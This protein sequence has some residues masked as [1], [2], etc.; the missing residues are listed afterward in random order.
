MIGSGC[1]IVILPKKNSKVQR[2]YGNDIYRVRH[3]V[4]NAF[5]R[6]SVG[7]VSPS[8]MHK[9]SLLLSPPYKYGAST[10]AEH[11]CL[12]LCRHY[13]AVGELSA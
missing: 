7:V 6:L 8:D 4:E 2:S 5:L 1:E 13:L 9:C 3:L 11:F 10:L 12:N